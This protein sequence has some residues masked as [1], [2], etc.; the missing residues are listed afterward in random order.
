MVSSDKGW[1]SRRKGCLV[2]YG[3]E[4]FHAD[5]GLHGTLLL[6]FSTGVLGQLNASSSFPVFLEMC[7]IW[8]FPTSPSMIRD[9]RPFSM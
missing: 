4:E 5:F 6:L 9:P 8:S 2:L 7:M 3:K 1:Y